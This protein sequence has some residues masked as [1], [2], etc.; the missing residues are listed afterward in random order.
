MKFHFEFHGFPRALPHLANATCRPFSRAGTP[1]MGSRPGIVKMG[2][3]PGNVKMETDFESK[4]SRNFQIQFAVC[5]SKFSSSTQI[6]L[7]SFGGP[8]RGVQS[9]QSYEY[10]IIL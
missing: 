1:K 9:M 2:S 6:K 5:A 4:Q 8:F 3:R 7:K 10:E